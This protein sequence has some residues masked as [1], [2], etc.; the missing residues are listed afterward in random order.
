[1]VDGMCVCVCVCVYVC[2]R[3]CFALEVGVC[4][5]LRFLSESFL[6]YYKICVNIFYVVR[7]KVS[8]AYDKTHRISRPL[9]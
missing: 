8:G 3:V 9:W 1:M 5:V 6:T 7:N 4:F 2:V